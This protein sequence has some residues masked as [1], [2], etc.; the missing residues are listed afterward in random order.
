MPAIADQ[1]DD[2]IQQVLIAHPEA[3]KEMTVY[4]PAAMTEHAPVQ[5][6]VRDEDTHD[7]VY[8]HLIR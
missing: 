4:L 5:W 6:V 3:G 8:W 2:P 7:A 1:Y